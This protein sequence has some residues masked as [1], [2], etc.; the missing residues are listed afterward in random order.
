MP[1][2]RMPLVL[3]ALALFLASFPIARLSLADPVEARAISG[4]P[5]EASVP[6][7]SRIPIRLQYYRQVAE[8]AVTPAVRP[9]QRLG[10][11]ASAVGVAVASTAVYHRGEPQRASRPASVGLR[12]ASLAAAARAAEA[13][14]HDA[15]GRALLIR[16]AVA[17]PGG[18]PRLGSL[19]LGTPH[20]HRAGALLASIQVRGPC[21]A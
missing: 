17:A 6:A 3:R 4:A 10:A 18:L 2:R 15:R 21:A 12:R 19:S 1:R 11:Q 8:S 13:A 20:P 7:L 9:V 14:R 16:A 5:R